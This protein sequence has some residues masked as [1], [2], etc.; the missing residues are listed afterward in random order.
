[1]QPTVVGQPIGCT[2]PVHGGQNYISRGRESSRLMIISSC[3]YF[4]LQ[5]VTAVRGATYSYR[6][7]FPSFHPA[8]KRGIVDICDV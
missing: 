1:M 5:R 8:I 6:A 7:T 2:A 3:V 4:R